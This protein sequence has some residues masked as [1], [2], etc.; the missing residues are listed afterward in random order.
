M[1]KSTRTTVEPITLT[2]ENVY[3]SYVTYPATITSERRE[4]TNI[5]NLISSNL[6]WILIIIIVAL[7][8]ALAVKTRRPAGKPSI[9]GRYCVNCGAQIPAA[10]AYCPHCGALQK[11]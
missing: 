5:T 6:T 7:I 8:A 11:E 3:T 2:L 10:V 9:I 4:E 1:E